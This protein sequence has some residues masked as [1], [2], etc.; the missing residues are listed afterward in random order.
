MVDAEIPEAHYRQ[1]GYILCKDHR[2][3]Y[4]VFI[5]EPRVST[6]HWIFLVELRGCG[7]QRKRKP[8]RDMA[9]YHIVAKGGDQCVR[10][11]R[12]S[13]TSK[14]RSRNQLS[15]NGRGRLLF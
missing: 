1:G 10:K 11:M 12:S 3:F 9:S 7:E 8:C 4:K 6:N 13:K 14:S 2:D 5:R 15:R